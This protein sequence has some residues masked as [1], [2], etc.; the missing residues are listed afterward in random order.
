MSCTII[1]ENTIM[2]KDKP[3]TAGSKM[4]GN[5]ISPITATV[6][7]RLEKAGVTIIDSLKHTTSTCP[8]SPQTLPA[9]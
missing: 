7:T 9:L 4:L 1:L 2:Q 5:F 8:P 3:A 6:A